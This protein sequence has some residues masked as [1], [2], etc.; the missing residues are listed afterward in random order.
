MYIPILKV[1]MWPRRPQ[2]LRYY[3]LSNRSVI[4]TGKESVYT[5]RNFRTSGCVAAGGSLAN[6]SKVR[7]RETSGDYRVMREERDARAKNDRRKVT[8]FCARGLLLSAEV[9]VKKKMTGGAD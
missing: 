5:H 6:P 3:S 9:Y 7:E 4:L 2:V 8:G 1:A